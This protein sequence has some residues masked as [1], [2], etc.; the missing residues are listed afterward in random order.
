MILRE[1]PDL[2]PRPLTP[3]NAA[4]R[5]HFYKCWGKENSIICGR[6]RFAEYAPH[7][8]SLSIKLAWGGAETYVVGK[9][10]V[11]VDD[12]SYLILNERQTYSSVL[13]G[14]RDIDS[15]C[16]F[17][18]PKM[19]DEVFS[20]MSASLTQAAD[21]GTEPALK[22]PAQ[23]AEHLRPHD[24]IVT[25]VLSQLVQ[26]VHQ[27]LDDADAIEEA[28]QDLLQRM[29]R[30][31]HRMRERERSIGAVKVSTRE[32]LLKRIDLATDYICSHHAT[33]ITLDDIAAAA[34]LSKFHLV[35]LFRQVHRMSPHQF[36]INRRL[37]AA[38]RLLYRRELNLDDVA[39]M[40]GFGT[41][42]S[43]F[44]HLR[45]NAGAGGSAIRN[46]H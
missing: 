45:R 23:F 13:R 14:E 39:V 27:G 3:S 32:E 44:R 28:L 25:P 31:N 43:L 21:D 33:P 30:T 9:R 26:D 40:A 7:T 37:A 29:I 8:Q 16:V 46:V 18:R 38:K 34:T 1:M 12:D 20:A 41:R 19:A 24:H 36:L 6:S 17:F 42:W 22:K 11:S 2:P 4:F 10:R 15:F 5:A 35:R